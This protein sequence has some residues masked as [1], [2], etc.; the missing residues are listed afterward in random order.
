MLRRFRQLL[1]SLLFLGLILAGLVYYGL[2]QSLPQLEGERL[3]AVDQ[4]VQIDRDNTGFV[5]IHASSELDASYALGFSH[6]QDRFFQ[7]DLLRRNAAGEL[8]ALFGAKALP[9]DKKRRLHRFRDRAEIAFA[10]LPQDHKNRLERYAEGV[11]AGLAS[12][13]LPPFEY[14]LLFSSPEKWLPVDSLLCIYSMYLDL[15]GMEGRDDLAQGV[16][17]Q[18]LPTDWYRFFNQHS[19]VFQAPLDDSAISEIALPA[20]EYPKALR[21]PLQACQQCQRKDSQDLGSNNFAVAGNRTADGRAIVA[22]DMHLSLRVP[23]IWYKAQLNIHHAEQQFT[24]TGVTLPGAPA[25]VAGSNGA[26]AWGF[27]NST[28]DWHDVISLTVDDTGRRYKTPL[29]FQEFSYNNEVIH[30]KGEPDEIIL[31]KETI[32]GPVLPAPFDQFALKWVAHD[33][34]AVNLNLVKLANATS[35]AEAIAIAPSVGVPTQNLVVADQAGK[36]GWT[37]I[38]PV[39]VR[40]LKDLNTPQDWSTGRNYWDGYLPAKS[41]PVVVNKDQLWTANARTVG[42]RALRRIGDGG[43]DL[44]ARGQQIRDGLA[45]L[46]VHTEQSLVQIQLDDRALMLRRWRELALAVLTD[47]FTASH[48]F[49]EARQAILERADRAS[50]E[51]DGYA[52]VRAFRNQVLDAI[53]APMASLMEQQQ[54]TL[55]DLKLV[56]ENA[57]W[58]LLQAKR[59]DTLPAGYASWQ[60]LLEQA[61]IQSVQQGQAYVPASN[62]RSQ[63]HFARWG[64]LNASQIQHPLSKA[65]PLL[66]PW[67]DMPIHPQSGDRHMPKVAVNGFGQSE[68]MVVSPGHE[69]DG[70][71][72]L[73]SG[74]SGHPLSEYYRAGYA[75]WQQQTNLP[76]LPQAKKYQ[77]ILQPQG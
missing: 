62:A 65:I 44:G 7:M 20:T 76:F 63:Q 33:V 19:A 58:L 2:Q 32:W 9:F 66:A 53:F 59:E 72:V 8:S 34:E 13:S 27:T 26:I 12:L 21:Q 10:A 3:A 23:G 36:I 75:A 52:L 64:V 70:V 50:V 17:K 5:S 15:Q 14:S 39:P 54:L 22:D 31:I 11:N 24:I 25:I 6:A 35:V 18:Q 28:A 42:G 29:G 38:G 49:A 73:P 47:E 46:P 45:A 55:A 40:Q 56:P 67:L 4:R 51:S 60:A 61:L 41:Y 43:Y 16:L 68:R 74:Q 48:Q 71:L 77:L 57:G 30:V 69:A 37:L 1:I